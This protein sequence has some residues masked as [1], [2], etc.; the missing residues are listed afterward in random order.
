MEKIKL[1]NTDYKNIKELFKDIRFFEIGEAFEEGEPDFRGFRKILETH[2]GKD[3]VKAIYESHDY[4]INGIMDFFQR[5]VSS[6]LSQEGKTT[7]GNS[8]K[9]E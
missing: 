9:E 5:A 4:N 1:N 8:W 3:K 7:S 6:A 2:M